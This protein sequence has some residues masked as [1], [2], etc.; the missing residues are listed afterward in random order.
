HARAIQPAPLDGVPQWVLGAKAYLDTISN[1]SRW[2][3]CVSLWLKLEQALGYPQES[4]SSSSRLSAKNRPIQVRQ[5]LQNCRNYEAIPS[6]GKVAE[7]GTSWRLWWTTLQPGARPRSEYN[8]LTRKRL[9]ND[10]WEPIKKA[11]PNGIFIRLVSL[12]WWV[13]A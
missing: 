11:G 4:Q 3:H 7:Y 1:D 8:E 6:I 12:G 2:N 10:A 13:K 5:W 9:S